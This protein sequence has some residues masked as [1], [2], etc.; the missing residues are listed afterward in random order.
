MPQDFR[1]QF[2]HESVSPKPLS[3]PLDRF[4]FFKNLRKYSQ[5]KVHQRQLCRQYGW[6]QWQ[7]CKGGHANF[8]KSPNSWAQF[9]IKNP[10]IS[11]ICESKISNPQISLD[12]AAYRISANVSSLQIANPQIFHHKTERMK[13]LNFFPPFIAKLSGRRYVWPNFLFYKNSN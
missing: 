4:K 13:Y 7:I 1:F 2:F 3:I 8:F 12:W 11:K 5:L 6:Q 10:Q 9:A